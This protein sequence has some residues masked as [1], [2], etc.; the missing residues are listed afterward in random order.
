M[1]MLLH[2]LRLAA[3]LAFYYAFAGY[4]SASSGGAPTILSLILPSVCFGLASRF[5]GRQPMQTL[6]GLAS[7][8]GLLLPGTMADKLVYLPMA[9]Y[10]IWMTARGDFSLSWEQQVDEFQWF[11]KLYPAFALV[12]GVA[13]NHSAILYGSLPI[14][15]AALM[16]RIFMMQTLRQEPAVY[17]S[18][19]YLAITGGLL[20][21]VCAL[22]FLFSREGL[23]NG[24]ASAA[25]TVYFGGLLP[26]L[27]KIMEG[28]AAVALWLFDVGG[29]L[30]VSVLMY[31]RHHKDIN[32][33]IINNSASKLQEM[34]DDADAPIN[35]PLV[36]AV[37]LG[38]LAVILLVF[39]V[40]KIARR[41]K[42]K[43]RTGGEKVLKRASTVISRRRWPGFF[44]SPNERVR[45]EYRA[46]LDYC[47]K[48]GVTIQ[49]SD[50]SLDI[51][52]R[53]ESMEPATEAELRQLYLKARYAGS[54]TAQ[55]ATRAAELVKTICDS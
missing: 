20:A 49:L 43:A 17:T 50:T 9:A 37:I 3:D 1:M 42:T 5:E 47:E 46:Y 22:A 18:P 33:T 41:P 12:L 6:C 32:N 39:V 28:V 15:I 29:E 10:T 21:A 51:A 52:G 16:L 13:W 44:L 11:W 24:V 54:A 4:F 30:I 23:M 40:Y 36:A 45:R 7:L 8:A 27:Q 53:V 25:G 35:G 14:G 19:K 48:H 55:D 38:V 26:L 34:A 2:G 31:L